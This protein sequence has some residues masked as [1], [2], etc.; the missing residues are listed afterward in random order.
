MINNWNVDLCIYNCSFN[1]F[2]EIS[3]IILIYIYNAID[4]R[5][6]NIP[7]ACLLQVKF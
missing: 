5:T 7:R 4:L 6:I 3:F 2:V 1:T